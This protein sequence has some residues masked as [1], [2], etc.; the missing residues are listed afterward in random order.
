MSFRFLNNNAFHKYKGLYKI[1]FQLLNNKP[2]T[3]PSFGST[4]AKGVIGP[5][6]RHGFSKY[7]KLSE[8]GFF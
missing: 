1:H 5:T 2:S 3:S 8:S 4:F 6:H 7:R